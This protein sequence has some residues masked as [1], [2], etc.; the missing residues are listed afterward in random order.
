MYKLNYYGRSITDNANEEQKIENFGMGEIFRLRK[1]A[2]HYL[3]E[4]VQSE[5]KERGYTTEVRAGSLYCYKS[6][7]TAEGN[8]KVRE[9]LIK[10]E[11]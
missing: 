11:K 6:E 9:I 8:R 7:K 2:L 4:K 5:Y 10:A 1:N 3:Y